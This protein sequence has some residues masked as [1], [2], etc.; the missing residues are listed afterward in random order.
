MIARTLAV[1]GIGAL[2]ATA[3]G[4]PAPYL[5]GTAIAVTLAGLGGWKLGIPPLMANLCFVII[6]M[7]IGAGVTPEVL[8]TAGRWP[9]SFVL[10]GVCL[11]AIMLVSMIWLT[12]GF[13]YDRTSAVLASAP[14]HLSYVLG[15]STSFRADVAMIGLVQSIRVLSITLIVPFLLP[16]LGVE[17]SSALLVAQPMTIAG[18]LGTL[19]L[20]VAAGY[21][22]LRLNV[23]AALLLGGMFVSTLLHISGTVEGAMPT[24]LSIPALV[25]MGCIIGSRFT[26]VSPAMLRKAALAGLMITLVSSAIAVIFAYIVALT[27]DL[28]FVQLVIAFTPGGVEVMVAM[29]MTMDVDPTFVA[30][31]HVM[32][33]FMLTFLVPLMLARQRPPPV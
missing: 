21:G 7:T 23:P 5:T 19:V 9:A 25:V 10:L 13:A 18:I 16:L 1:G 29:A 27:L 30:A 24:W 22:L 33:L 17:M 15:L 14:G 26:G 8:E 31:H 28:P 20:S 32:R 11:V 4:M 2:A 12:R 6:G 3:I